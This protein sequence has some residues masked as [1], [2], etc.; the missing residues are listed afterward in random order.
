MLAGPARVPG[1]HVPRAADRAA[2]CR[3]RARGPG[4]S[5][6]GW[7]PKMCCTIRLMFSVSRIRRRS[8]SSLKGGGDDGDAV[9]SEEALHQPHELRE[10]DLPAALPCGLIWSKTSRAVSN[11]IFC[12]RN[13]RP[14]S[15]RSI[16]VIRRHVRLALDHRRELGE[17]ARVAQ[18]SSS[19]GGTF[20][21]SSVRRGTYVVLDAHHV[22]P[23]DL[24]LRL[25]GHRLDARL[26]RR[27]W[28]GDVVASFVRQ[29]RERHAEDVHVLGLEE[30]RP[31]PTS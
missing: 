24:E 31:G 13:S 14:R 3:T 30:A 20:A 10:Q 5:R 9:G 29:E 25:L 27:G 12:I 6:G 21:K 23:R 19:S 15:S 22:R 16:S 1:Q 7:P 11:T 28:R 4:C 2:R 8:S 26:G 17:L 18:H